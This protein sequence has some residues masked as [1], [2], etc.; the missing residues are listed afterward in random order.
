MTRLERI[1]EIETLTI[2][3]YMKMAMAYEETRNAQRPRMAE[4]LTGQDNEIVVA[5]AGELKNLFYIAFYEGY[6]ASNAIN[7]EFLEQARKII[8]R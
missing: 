4:A 8:T 5:E 7:A 2:E 6:Q 1:K 3:K